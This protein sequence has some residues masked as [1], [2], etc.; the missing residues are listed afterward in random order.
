LIFAFD[1]N[2][3]PGTV[4][5]ADVGEEYDFS[6]Y[7]ED[8]R[9][10]FKRLL[11]ISRIT[12]SKYRQILCRGCHRNN[13]HRVIYIRHGDTYFEAE[14][15]FRCVRSYQ[16][17]KDLQSKIKNLRATTCNTKAA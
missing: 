1:A 2:L 13:A 17:L 7:N 9:V 6:I 10:N 16:E 14:S 11:R 4:R 12:V 3:G 8:Q 5:L 15:R